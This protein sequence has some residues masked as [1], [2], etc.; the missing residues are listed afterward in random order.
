MSIDTAV[1]A[2]AMLALALR[3]FNRRDL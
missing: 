1:Y 3:A 2:A